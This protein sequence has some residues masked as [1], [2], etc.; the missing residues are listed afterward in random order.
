M[1]Q[2]VDAS[3]AIKWY[4][5]EQHNAEAKL[6]LDGTRELYAPELILVEFGSIIWKKF[7]RGELTESEARQITGEFLKVK[8]KIQRHQPLLSAALYGAMQSNQTVY[9]WSYLALAVALD[10]EM[11]TADEKFYR[12][13]ETIKLKRHLLFVADIT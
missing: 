4:S 5:P 3:T 11:V 8:I 2:V 10:C 6:L 9:D 7:R 1:I 13:L 12:A